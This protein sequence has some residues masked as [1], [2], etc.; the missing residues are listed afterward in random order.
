MGLAAASSSHDIRK[1]RFIYDSV[2]KSVHRLQNLGICSSTYGTILVPVILKKIRPD[3]KLIIL[4]SQKSEEQWDLRK[5]LDAFK[6]GLEAREKANYWQKIIQDK[7]L[8]NQNLIVTNHIYRE[9][10]YNIG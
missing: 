1:V 7:C 4:L 9:I 10:H 2:E 8:V 5:L 6:T 3:M